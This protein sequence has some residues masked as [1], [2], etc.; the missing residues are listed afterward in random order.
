MSHCRQLEKGE[1]LAQSLQA[2]EEAFKEVNHKS[3]ANEHNLQVGR[4]WVTLIKFA[5]VHTDFSC[6]I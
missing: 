1:G 2:L 5:C 4:V 6:L 3:E